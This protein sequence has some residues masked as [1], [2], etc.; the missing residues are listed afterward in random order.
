[1][2]LNFFQ[3][4]QREKK[5]ITP[6]GLNVTKLIPFIDKQSTQLTRLN[7]FAFHDCMTDE[8]KGTPSDSSLDSEMFIAEE[9]SP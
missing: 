5:I 2:I 1:M 7:L 6:I 4:E 3:E 9:I 8:W